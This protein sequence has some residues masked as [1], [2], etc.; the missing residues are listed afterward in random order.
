[1]L[2]KTC[3]ERS[4]VTAPHF[5]RQKLLRRLTNDV[6]ASLR[7]EIGIFP[8]HKAEVGVSLGLSSFDLRRCLNDVGIF[9]ECL[10][11]NGIIGSHENA[12][13]EQRKT[14]PHGFFTFVRPFSVGR[15]G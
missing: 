3:V 6:V 7:D 5:E 14:R 4:Q 11:R 15:N 12:S 10:A 2:G 13:F 9:R 8:G 1:M